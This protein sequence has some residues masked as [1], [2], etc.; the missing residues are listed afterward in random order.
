MSVVDRQAPLDS[1]STAPPLGAAQPGVREAT[2]AQ[3]VVQT[4]EL[5]SRLVRDE[6]RLAQLELAAKGKRMGMGIGMFGGAGVFAFYG[7][8]VGIAAAVIAI[9]LVL[10]A[11]GAALIVM[12]A[13]FLLAGILALVG[14]G[15]FKRAVPPAPEQTMASVKQ[16][17]RVISEAR[18]R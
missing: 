1:I 2:V 8:G 18:R 4:T 6:I 13:L 14:K 3:L 15:Q 12:G 11:W 17:L 9:A 16:D 10:P 7:T 5:T